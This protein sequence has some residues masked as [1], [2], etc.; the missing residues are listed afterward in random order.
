MLPQ[1]I[2][3][4]FPQ[5]RTVLSPV[6]ART[7]LDFDPDDCSVHLEIHF[8]RA[9]WC[10]KLEFSLVFAMKHLLRAILSKTLRILGIAPHA[11]LSA[12]QQLLPG[13]P[14]SGWA[15]ALLDGKGG[16]GGI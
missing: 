11:Q 14:N 5:P 6:E 16:K 3:P 2:Q 7:S 4:H 13:P 12:G 15:P 9:L 8:K 10:L 1:I